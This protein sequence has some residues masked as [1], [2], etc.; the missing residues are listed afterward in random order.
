LF[1]QKVKQC[2]YILDF[3]ESLAQL[4]KKELKREVLCELVQFILATR[5][6]DIT[7]KMYEAVKTMARK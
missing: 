2:C 3:S 1:I 6:L 4:Q 5:N 7:P